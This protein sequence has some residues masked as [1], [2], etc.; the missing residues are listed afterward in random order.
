[1]RKQILY[2]MSLSVSDPD[3]GN[4]ETLVTLQKGS[5]VY[6]S[7]RAHKALGYCWFRHPSGYHLRFTTEVV[8]LEGLLENYPPRMY[9]YD[10][11]LYQG[12]CAIRVSNANVSVDSGEWTCHLGVPGSPE[13]DR[14]VP[15][16]VGVSG[17]YVTIIVPQTKSSARNCTFLI[18]ADCVCVIP[19]SRQSHCYISATLCE[20][21]TENQVALQVSSWSFIFTQLYS[22]SLNAS[23]AG[24]PN[25]LKAERKA[26][27]VPELRSWKGEVCTNCGDKAVC[28]MA[29]NRR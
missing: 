24:I 20:T 5:D 28:I 1:M 3:E 9:K 19:F 11:T 26:I 14:S 29:L 18:H 7:C 27:P 21:M 8:P 22:F 15:I 16:T 6:L 10:D 2:D 4:N 17:K 12:V 25:T 13:E 23:L